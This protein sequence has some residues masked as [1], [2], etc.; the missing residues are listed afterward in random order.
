MSTIEG[1]HLSPQQRRVWSLGLGDGSGYCV[2]CCA[3]LRGALDR[4]AFDAALQQVVDRHEILRTTFQHLPGMSIPLQVVGGGSAL[5]R[6][7]HDLSG[8]ELGEQEARVEALVRAARRTPFDAER[9]PLLRVALVTL[10]P[11]SH[12]LIVAASA[13]CVDNASLANLARAIGRSYATILGQEQPGD[14]PVQYADVA[15][16]QNEI[17]D[18]DYGADGRAFWREQQATAHTLTLPFERRPSEAAEFAPELIAL[19]IGAGVA[20]GIATLAERDGIPPAAV[21]LACWYV[22]LWRL[23]QQ[24]ELVVGVAFE[25]RNYDGLADALGPFAKYVPVRQELEA[26]LRFDGL[27]RCIATQLEAASKWQEYFTWGDAP[28]TDAAYFPIGFDFEATPAAYTAVDVSVSMLKP[29]ACIDQFNLRLSCALVGGALVADLH[30]DPRAFS[31]QAAERLAEQ[32]QTLLAGALKRPEAPI[33]TL[34]LLSAAERQRLLA[35]FNATAAAYPNDTPAHRLFEQQVRRTPDDIAVVCPSGDAGPGRSRQL[36]YAELDVRANQ[37]AHELRALGVGPDVPVAVCMERST[38]LLVALL[39]V[40]KAGGAYVPLDPTYP[41]QRLAWMLRDTGAP[42]LLTTQEQRTKNQEQSTTERK[43]VLHTPPEDDERA[44]RTTPPEDDERAYRTTPPVDPGQPTVIDLEADWER[45]ARRPEMSPD[46]AVEPEHLAYVIYTSGS[47]GQPKGAMIPH[48]GLV[49]YLSWCARTYPL[50]GGRGAPV[51]SSIGFDLTITSLLAPLFAGRSVVL[52]PEDQGILALGAALRDYAGW[53]L[54]KI[55]PAHLGVLREQLAPHQAAGRTNA[56]IIGGENLL[57]EQLTF[58]QEAAPETLLINE[59][60]PTETV[61]GCCVYQVPADQHEPGAI[62]IGRP[63]ANTQIYILDAN[64]NPVP[65]GVPGELYIGGAQLARGY[66]NRPDLTAERFVP[67]PFA[68]ERLEIGDWRLGGVESPISNLQSPI[69][70]RLYKTGDL[71]RHRPDGNIEFLGRLD[72]QVKLRGYRIEPGEIEATLRGHPGVRDCIVVVREEEGGNARLIAYVVPDQEQRTKNKE[73]RSEEADSQF[74]ILNSQFSD[75]LRAFLTQ[76][77]PEYMVPAAFVLL[78]ALPLTPN[79]KID[80]CALPAPDAARRSREAEFVA[81]R[82]PEETTLAAIWATVL[83]RPRVGIH[84]NFFALGGDSILS[85]QIIAKAH[86]AGLHLTPR[87]MFQHQT[88]AELAAVAG[89]AA[90]V[91]AEQGL[92]QGSVPLT[93]IQQA[94]FDWDLPAPHHYNQAL[95]LAVQRRLEPALL[96]RALDVVLAHHDALRLRFIRGERWQQHNAA[97]NPPVLTHVD[98]SGLPAERQSAALEAAAAAMQPSLDLAAGPLL[99]AALF[100]LGHD[101]PQRLLLVIHH[102]AVDGVSWRILM[103]DL[104]AAYTQLAANQPVALPAKTT[105]FQDWAER[106]LAYAQSAELEAEREHWL[107]LARTPSTRL[108]RDEPAGPNTAFTVEQVTGTLSAAE[109]QALL[110]DVPQVYHTQINDVLLTALAQAAHGWTGVPRLLV[111]LEGH[112][113]EDLFADVDLS[114]TVGW[115]TSLFPVLLDLGAAHGPGAALQAVKEQL[116]QVPNRG[117]GYGIM[118]YL[119]PDPALREALAAE[120][121][122]ISFNY[123]GQVDQ[124]VAAPDELF[125]MAPE[126]SGPL[127]DQR[128]LRRHLL[129]V[130][131][132]VAGGRLELEL[133]YSTS[134]HRRATIERLLSRYLAALRALIAHCQSPDAGGFTPSDFPL[135]GLNQKKMG[136]LTAMLDKLDSSKEA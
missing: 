17:L 38:E 14:E 57:A 122:E 44:Y 43:G 123:L 29:Y 32:Y 93:P 125:R 15:E 39:G 27:L 81:P 61:V 107:R 64:M 117:I 72:Q 71:A 5:L 25:G 65:V 127:Q 4:R 70:D 135:A 92:V 79:G 62:P 108:L 56:F 1:Y 83:R 9:G 66:L 120:Q 105:S 60:G 133:T 23:S 7:D 77:L 85:I 89:T 100:D 126:L 80:R 20:G 84:D 35:Q 51:H 22:L 78:D 136:K 68:Q 36:T 115:F 8:L 82:T 28:A 26:G 74:S 119:S 30:Y 131:G 90:A 49:N 118:R 10:S 130:S 91:P 110:T 55:T 104:P 103:E 59:Y 96:A 76:R 34:D 114:R 46:I 134:V 31:A 102:L 129:E 6:D 132:I 111:E 94:F 112:G 73:Q 42:V 47:T 101:Q 2:Q 75:K 41:Q 12:L 67:N 124:V 18:A 95:L 16:W 19:A 11:H 69:S 24:R 86:Q 106:L 99:R 97:D 88:I 53:S 52:L 50:A 33:D 21:P 45:I 40:L 113:R 63:I 48:R 54:V 13:L 128:G 58:W 3:S 98:L 116:R 109:T 121:A 87:Q 37:L